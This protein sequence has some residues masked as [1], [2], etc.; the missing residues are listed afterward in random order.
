[1]QIHFFF[2]EAVPWGF[3]SVLTE[4]DNHLKSYLANWIVQCENSTMWACLGSVDLQGYPVVFLDFQCMGSHV[5]LR[6]NMP[7]MYAL[8]PA[9]SLWSQECRS[10]KVLF[11][12]WRTR[13]IIQGLKL[14]SFMWL[15]PI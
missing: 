13:K 2:L 3:Q 4:L 1:M 9:A 6:L 11:D 14:L 12:Q 5:V 7:N 8:T 15:I 10:F